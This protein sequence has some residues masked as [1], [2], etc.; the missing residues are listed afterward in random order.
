MGRTNDAPAFVRHAVGRNDWV[1]HDPEA[2][3]ALRG[4]VQE[5]ILVFK[6]TRTPNGFMQELIL[7]FMDT[8]TKRNTAP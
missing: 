8:Y 2:D 1:L 4:F 6:W 7:V 3:W 5:V